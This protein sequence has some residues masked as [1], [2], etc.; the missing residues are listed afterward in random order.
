MLVKFTIHR[1][2][3]PQKQGVAPG[4]FQSVS[5]DTVIGPCL[6]KE[7]ANIYKERIKLYE[8]RV[9]LKNYLKSSF[10]E[11]NL[12]A[13][14]ALPTARNMM[15]RLENTLFPNTNRVSYSSNPS[16]EE[17][18]AY[19]VATA[20]ADTTSAPVKISP[21]K[22]APVELV[23][24]ETSARLSVYFAQLLHICRRITG[25]P[26]YD[27]SAIRKLI[28]TDCDS[29]KT[30]AFTG[31]PGGNISASR[32]IYKVDFIIDYATL[33]LR[34]YT[35]CS[36]DPI[37]NTERGRDAGV[38]CLEELINGYTS[39]IR[40]LLNSF[41]G[42]KK[43]F[44]SLR[45]Q[46]NKNLMLTFLV[47]EDRRLDIAIT[48][49]VSA[50]A[51]YPRPK[52]CLLDVEV[53]D[54]MLSF[55]GS[56]MIDD[57]KA[58]LQRTVDHAKITKTNTNALPW[59]IEDVNGLKM[60]HLPET[61]MQQFNVYLDLR[62]P[63]PRPDAF[64]EEKDRAR[65]INDRILRAV[66][67]SLML[68]VQEYNRALQAKKWPEFKSAADAGMNI[69]FLCSI[70]NDAFR[71]CTTHMEAFTNTS[72]ISKVSDQIVS[73]L[74]DEFN[75]I[76]DTALRAL[77]SVMSSDFKQKLNDFDRI[78]NTSNDPIV[79]TITATLTDYFRDLKP[80]LEIHTYSKLVLLA[81]DMCVIRYIIF[82]KNKGTVNNTKLTTQVVKKMKSDIDLWKG[83]FLTA[84]QG[85]LEGPV[86]DKLKYLDDL[87]ALL[88]LDYTTPAYL[89]VVN[90]LARKYCVDGRTAMI[91]M[92]TI[93][94]SLRADGG[95]RLQQAVDKIIDKFKGVAN[96]G[97]VN[98]TDDVF[99]R[100]F[101]EESDA[102]NA[103]KAGGGYGMFGGSSSGGAGK[104]SS[105]DSST[106]GKSSD[107]LKRQ[108]L[109]TD[110]SATASEDND[111]FNFDHDS[112]TA[113]TQFG[114]TGSEMGDVYLIEIS[115]IQVCST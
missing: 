85:G 28:R 21:P 16:G 67:N 41:V 71:L 56:A 44:L 87:Y 106:S 25:G 112:D 31:T 3:K 11:T 50:I 108:S 42:S 79:G 32:I 109:A 66:G 83:C 84:I 9:Q 114:E 22:P 100:A 63:P 95:F 7:L 55:Y 68:L 15:D 24:L 43:A 13:S 51:M 19:P 62:V 40:S 20:T 57:A 6:A 10:A 92:I 58:W 69:S 74:I 49:I 91:R 35:L 1:A 29:D 77:L 53:M 111:A 99:I 60:S 93:S 103:K 82:I 73:Q 75:N 36:W 39:E 105:L 26:V 81:A 23:S 52:A 61:I 98:V 2:P 89:D 59:D 113:S 96:P 72:T 34:D 102:K 97:E 38:A 5:I 46:E 14:T 45:G 94:V 101:R 86:Q 33:R 78:W 90:K 107:N 12:S 47:K 48:K 115:E 54:S 104:R 18:S 4:A 64:E 27:R 17:K 30:T 76:M 88:T 110:I 80:S 65:R 70:T 37:T 8:L